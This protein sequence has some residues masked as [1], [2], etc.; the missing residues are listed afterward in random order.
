MRLRLLGLSLLVASC[1]KGGGGD[2]TSASSTRQGLNLS[3]TYQLTRLL[4]QEGSTYFTPDSETMTMNIDRNDFYFVYG[5][6]CTGQVKFHSVIDEKYINL[7]DGYET[8]NTCSGVLKPY[9]KPVSPQ[10]YTFSLSPGK[11]RDTKLIYTAVGDSIIIP[12]PFR[13]VSG[14]CLF[15]LIK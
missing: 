6:P 10:V 8:G 15:E 2:S 12:S 13:T 7:T 3:G 11:M 1:G 4:C 5:H 14:I 9:A